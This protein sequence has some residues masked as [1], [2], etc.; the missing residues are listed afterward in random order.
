MISVLFIAQS[1]QGLVLLW[2]V[3]CLLVCL[4]FV[5]AEI[6][7]LSHWN[8][9]AQ[10][11]TREIQAVWGHMRPFSTSMTSRNICTQSKGTWSTLCSVMLRYW[12]ESGISATYKTDQHSVDWTLLY[13]VCFHRI[14][15]RR[16]WSAL[17]CLPCL[18]AYPLFILQSSLLYSQS[19][20][21][22][23]SCT[24]KTSVLFL[25]QKVFICFHLLHILLH[26][27][28]ILTGKNSNPSIYTK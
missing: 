20:S 2:C 13:V 10:P 1:L 6:P 23:T 15:L 17:R 21:C 28:F 22:A 12:L 27:T 8:R 7:F 11:N 5:F 3:N 18:H 16:L 14:L 9:L 19:C 25:L 26:C 4:L 24:S